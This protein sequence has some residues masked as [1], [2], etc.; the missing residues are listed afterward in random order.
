MEE[1]GKTPSSSRSVTD[2]QMTI[3]GSF[4]KAIPLSQKAIPLSQSSE[5]LMVGSVEA[6][7]DHERL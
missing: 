4:S 7:D 6:H 1:F 2:Q 3:E 5:R